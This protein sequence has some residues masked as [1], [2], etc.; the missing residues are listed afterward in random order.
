MRLSFAVVLFKEGLENGGVMVFLVRVIN[1]YS[2]ASHG[3]V[4]DVTEK[5]YKMNYCHQH[6]Q[7]CGGS[8]QGVP[9]QCS[10]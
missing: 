9:H 7:P 2:Q 6:V 10:K 5:D 8:V 3:L 4:S 1:M